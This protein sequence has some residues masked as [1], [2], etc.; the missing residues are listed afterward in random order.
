MPDAKLIRKEMFGDK[1][2]RLEAAIELEIET[3][4]LKEHLNYS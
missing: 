3:H 1:P 4:Y 2:K